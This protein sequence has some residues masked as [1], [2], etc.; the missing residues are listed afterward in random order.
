LRLV[1]LKEL[2]LLTPVTQETEHLLEQLVLTL[3]QEELILAVF[4]V[5]PLFLPHLLALIQLLKVAVGVQQTAVAVV[6]FNQHVLALQL[7]T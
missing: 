5:Q 1:T 3:L 4:L 2:P 7:V 6:I